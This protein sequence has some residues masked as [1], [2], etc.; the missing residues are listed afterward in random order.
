MKE[1]VHSREF[2]IVIT[3]D[4]AANTAQLAYN[5]EQAPS[6]SGEIRAHD[7]EDADAFAA[8]EIPVSVPSFDERT[9]FLR[10]RRERLQRELKGMQEIKDMCDAAARRGARRLATGGFLI[11][12]TYWLSVIRFT[13]FTPLGWDFMEVSGVD[14]SCGSSIDRLM[15][16]LVKPVTYLTEFLVIMGGYAWQVTVL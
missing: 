10:R 15:N 1:A 8:L 4:R 16:R 3:P 6:E 11:L 12:L 9:R 7:E 13:F 2:T 5:D 14:S